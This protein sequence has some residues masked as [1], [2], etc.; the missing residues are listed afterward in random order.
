M[1]WVSQK[2]KEEKEKKKKQG[3]LKGIRCERVKEAKPNLNASRKEGKLGEKRRE[4]RNKEEK[5]SRGGEG[6]LCAHE[7]G[8]KRAQYHQGVNCGGNGVWKLQKKKKKKGKRRVS[9]SEKDEVPH[10]RE[11]KFWGKTTCTE[12]RGLKKKRTKKRIP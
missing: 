6:S 11:G 10:G 3:G 2:R 4:S 5:K 1:A 7:S 9:R 12:K 8:K